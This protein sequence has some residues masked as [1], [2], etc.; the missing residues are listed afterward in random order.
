MSPS[1]GR[2]YHSMIGWRDKHTEDTILSIHGGDVD[3]VWSLNIAGDTSTVE[4]LPKNDEDGCSGFFHC[5]DRRVIITLLAV[6]MF[7]IIMFLSRACIAAL[8]MIRRKG[9]HENSSNAD[10]SLAGSVESEKE[11]IEGA[12]EEGLGNDKEIQQKQEVIGNDTDEGLGDDK[13]TP[14]KQE[15]IESDTEERLGDEEETQQKQEVE[16]AIHVHVS[17]VKNFAKN[18]GWTSSR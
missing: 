1:I 16:T 11:L 8:K 6:S 3:G 5:M 14:Q 17:S 15:T 10:L 2:A 4:F 9:I 7:C 12:A 13:E 18:L